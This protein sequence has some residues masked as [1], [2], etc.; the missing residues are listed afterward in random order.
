MGAGGQINCMIC[1]KVRIPQGLEI[2]EPVCHL[3]RDDH[4]RLLGCLLGVFK[5][6]TFLVQYIILKKYPGLVATQTLASIDLGSLQL[7]GF[8]NVMLIGKARRRPHRLKSS[9][10]GSTHWMNKIHWSRSKIAQF[11]YVV[12]SRYP[13][14]PLHSAPLQIPLGRNKKKKK[15]KTVTTFFSHAATT[16]GPRHTIMVTS[17]RLSGAASKCTAT[18]KGWVPAQQYRVQHH[19]APWRWR[20]RVRCSGSVDREADVQKLCVDLTM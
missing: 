3:A 19:D 14:K 10:M 2:D 17:K 15:S 9:H 12:L 6:G 1:R 16:A 4:I 18:R 8:N 11:I 7:S 20:R 5:V 13:L